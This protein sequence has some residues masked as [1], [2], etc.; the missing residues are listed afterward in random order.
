[1]LADFRFAFRLLLPSPGYSA[2]A[3][4][5]LGFGIGLPATSDRGRTSHNPS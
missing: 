4:G 5:A 2:A 1:V 3:I